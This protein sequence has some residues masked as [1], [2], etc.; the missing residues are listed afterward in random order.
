MRR[1]WIRSCASFLT[2]DHELCRKREV[3]GRFGR[4]PPTNSYNM[5]HEP[6]FPP[7]GGPV[8]VPT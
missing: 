1:M 4:R 8:C 5:V 2:A 6:L 7:P 3:A